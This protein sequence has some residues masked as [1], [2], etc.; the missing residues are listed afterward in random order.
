MNASSRNERGMVFQIASVVICVACCGCAGPAE[1]LRR[2]GA[3][4]RYYS[5]MDVMH[6]GCSTYT[7]NCSTYTASFGAGGSVVDA[8]NYISWSADVQAP[9]LEVRLLGED[10]REMM[11][12]LV[13]YTI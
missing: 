8:E 12:I 4:A 13:F 1:R 11:A 3:D 6:Y 2:L 5:G 9:V 10:R 7:T